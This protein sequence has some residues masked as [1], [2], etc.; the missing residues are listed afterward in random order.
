MF[1]FV[2]SEIKRVLSG[3][4]EVKRKNRGKNK[5]IGAVCDDE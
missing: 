4:N 3:L 2:C 1:T 5:N